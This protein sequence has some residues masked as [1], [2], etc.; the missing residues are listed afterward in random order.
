[1]RDVP[2]TGQG[3]VT[4]IGGGL[5]GSEAAW[6]LAGRGHSVTLVEM[7]PHVASPAHST[8][9]LAELVCSNSLKS[10]DPNTA[11]GGLKYELEHLGSLILACAR[12]T[13]V[14][15]G[16]A[17]A[18]DRER[19]A[20]AVTSSVE[21]H[22]AIEVVREE[23]ASLPE[24]PVVLATGPLTSAALEPPLSVLV[25][26]G[27]LAFFDAAAPIV[28]A[29][30]VERRV[31]FAASRYGKGEGS[32]YLNCPFTEVRYA[33]FVREL[34]A[35]ERV[36]EHEF[37]PRH[38]FAG[39][40]PIEE[41]ARRGSDAPRFGPMKPVG[42][43]DPSTGER[44]YA[45]VQLRAENAAATAYN[46]VGFQTNLT[47][48][49]QDR[50]FRMIPGLE[51][52]DFLRHG[53]MHRNTF[54]DSPRLLAADLSLREHP[55]LWVAGQLCGTEGYLEA[56]GTGLLAAANVHARATGAD[57]VVL[58]GDTFLGSLVAY[59]TDPATVG[60]QPMHVNLGL[61]PPLE[62]G[63]GKRERHATLARRARD[64]LDA[65]LTSHASFRPLHPEP[66]VSV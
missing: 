66:A 55:L 30:T 64:S 27:R 49:E 65:W 11:P 41:I 10:A 45:V 19:F 52:A 40:Q 31:V 50:V 8:A 29:A 33:D 26:P 3:A 48:G 61:L 51:R 17:L 25:G 20:A 63:L 16:T 60:Y 35:A 5:A 7:R 37:E 18:V 59:A 21:S 28:D 9:M 15:A 58:P 12:A 62:T 42:L 39:C 36:V 34:V 53:V 22:P 44:P 46:L 54:L 47:F 14:P 32:D 57:P 56:A 23:A 6:Q 24:G 2:T 13:A 38:L 43:V 1:M 4:V